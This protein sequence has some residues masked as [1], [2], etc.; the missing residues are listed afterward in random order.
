MRRRTQRLRLI[1]ILSLLA[2]ASGCK[3][4]CGGCGEE[5][6][7]VEGQA[8]G[9]V[10]E[11]PSALTTLFASQ[12]PEGTLGLVVARGFEDVAGTFAALKERIR[13]FFDLGQ[14]ESEVR[15]TFGVDLYRHVTFREAGIAY[16]GGFAVGIAKART[17]RAR[18]AQAGIPAD[19]DADRA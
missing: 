14:V 12:F 1:S 10:P 16:D 19:D 17:P 7:V 3:G 18:S 8:E 11:E 15:N 2:L 6:G 9:Q 5:G 4:G 13:D